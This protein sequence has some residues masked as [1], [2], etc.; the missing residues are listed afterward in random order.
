MSPTAG[1]GTADSA[2]YTVLLP[3]ATL[4]YAV[5]GDAIGLPVLFQCGSPGSR[6]G[7]E[8]VASAAIGS[9]ARLLGVDR[10]GMGR[11]DLHPGRRLMDWPDD[12]A[13]LLGR[14]RPDRRRDLTRRSGVGSSARSPTPTERS[15]TTP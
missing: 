5:F 7:P 2:G 11:S 9:G 15:F 4:A 13:R 14:R 1:A 6:L 3:G 10:P 12:V 8:S